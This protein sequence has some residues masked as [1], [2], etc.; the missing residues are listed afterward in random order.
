MDEDALDRY[1]RHAELQGLTLSEW[2]R[3]A[4]ERASEEEPRTSPEAR[5]EALDRALTC[6]HPTGDID[7]MLAGL[8]HVTR[9]PSS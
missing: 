7:E 5:L 8:A 6:D 1:R 3:R 2:V 9:L 4:L